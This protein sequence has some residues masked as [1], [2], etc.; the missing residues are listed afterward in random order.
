[1]PHYRCLFL[2]EDGQVA[3]IEELNN[4]DDGAA[5][6]DAVQLLTRTG[7]FS[8]FE[9]WREGRKVDVQAG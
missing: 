6:R 3:R 1:M 4:Y 2:R 7:G 8:G 9:L 5:R